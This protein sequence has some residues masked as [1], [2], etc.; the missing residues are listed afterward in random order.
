M[1]S[2]LGD[3]PAPRKRGRT[4]RASNSSARFWLRT[5]GVEHEVG[6]AQIDIALHAGRGLIGIGCHDEAGLGTVE[7]GSAR[8]SS[9]IG[10]SVPLFSSAERA[11]PAHQ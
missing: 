6:E 11:R 8:R 9:S 2:V 7:V 10:S 5:R 1:A 4:S 3:A